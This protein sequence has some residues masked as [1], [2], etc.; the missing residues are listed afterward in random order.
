MVKIRTYFNRSSG[1]ILQE[2]IAFNTLYY[3]G[4]RGRET[5]RFLEKDS[6][7]IE[8]DSEDREYIR[9][10]GDRLSKNCK[11][12]L[13]PADFEN[14]KKV[15]CYAPPEK[16][17]QCLVACLKQYLMKIPENVIDFFP[18]PIKSSN[19]SQCQYWYSDKKCIGKNTLCNLMSDLSNKL[20]LKKALHKPLYTCN[21]GCRAQR[22]RF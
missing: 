10:V 5:L 9:L 22:T 6:F 7:S 16:P 12:S 2:E 14:A 18:M 4:L 3:F 17:D 11:A 8:C 1:K 15:P 13:K 21:S 20:N 19:T